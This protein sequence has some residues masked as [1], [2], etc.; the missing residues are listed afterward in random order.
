MWKSL[1]NYK[2]CCMHPA[3]L[4]NSSN[5]FYIEHNSFPS[6]LLEHLDVLCYHTKKA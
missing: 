1:H 6:A 5:Q 4:V 3:S 2:V